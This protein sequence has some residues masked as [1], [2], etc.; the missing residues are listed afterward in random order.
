MTTKRE[1]LLEQIKQTIAALFI[2]QNVITTRAMRDGFA[3]DEQDVIV[4]HRGTNTPTEAIHTVS[5]N[6][7]EVLVS[8]FTRSEVPDRKADTYLELIHPALIDGAFVDAFDVSSGRTDEPQY[9]GSDGSVALINAR[10]YVQ[11]R[12]SANSLSS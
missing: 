11:Y 10:F 2:G 1:R 8:I 3:V 4:I 9:S 12:T 6:T 5:D 7:L